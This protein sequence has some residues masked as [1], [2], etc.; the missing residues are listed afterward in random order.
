MHGHNTTLQKDVATQ[1]LNVTNELPYQQYAL[2]SWLS[3]VYWL[4]SSCLMNVLVYVIS[5]SIQFGGL[6]M[7]TTSKIVYNITSGT[8]M[9]V[10]IT[11]A[12]TQNLHIIL[13]IAKGHTYVEKQK[14]MISKNKN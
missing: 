6:A 14:S 11:I 13:T 1:P 3:V 2:L 8:Y 7:A 10:N 4:V 12:K 9:P 5:N